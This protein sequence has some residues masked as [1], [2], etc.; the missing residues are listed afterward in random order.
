M[1]RSKVIAVGFLLLACA[2]LTAHPATRAEASVPRTPNNG[3]TPD[4]GGAI[5]APETELG[6]T[7][8]QGAF[9]TAHGAFTA[10]GAEACVRCQGRIG[11]FLEYT[12][13]SLTPA[14]GQT[15]LLNLGGGGIRIQGKNRYVRPFLDVGIAVGIYDGHPHNYVHKDES[16][17]I[18]GVM[19]GFGMTVSLPKGF[20]VRPQAKVAVSPETA[21]GFAS[22]GL[23]YRF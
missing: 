20:Y 16:F 10:V 8:G 5:G 22:V 18:M 3:P 9:L 21:V 17:D 13:W 1:R 19:L 4:S 2:L 15:S 12:H 7:L 6:A 23:G 14:G 11:Y